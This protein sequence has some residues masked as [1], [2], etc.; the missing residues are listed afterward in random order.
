MPWYV[1]AVLAAVVWGMHYP[2]VGRFLDKMSMATLFLCVSLP[3]LYFAV[4]HRKDIAKDYETFI[5]LS[6]FDKAQ[7]LSV[8]VTALAGALLV[9]TAIDKSNAT[10]ASLIEVSYPVFVA[11]FSYFVFKENHLSLPTIIGGTLAFV[12]AGI[13]IYFNK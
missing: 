9:W 7:S 11:L 1:S 5:A 2:L 6:A 12:G 4:A 3:S 8:I 13:V 10:H